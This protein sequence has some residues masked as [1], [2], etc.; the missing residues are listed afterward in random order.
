MNTKIKV[1]LWMLSLVSAFAVTNIASA[2]FS[3]KSAPV[4]ATQTS[5]WVNLTW[6]KVDWATWYLVMY[7]T[8]TGSGWSYESELQDL[9]EWTWAFV[10][11][12]KAWKYFFAVSAF[13][14]EF[15]EVTSPELSADFAWNG[16]SVTTAVTTTS[17][18]TMTN[19]EILA[20]NQVKV[21]FSNDLSTDWAKEFMLTPKDNKNSEVK[22]TE[23]VLEWTKDLVL[24]LETNLDP[25]IEY[26]LV[27]ISA[28]DKDGNTI[29]SG[30]DWM[31][32][33]STPAEFPGAENVELN[34]AWPWDLAVPANGTWV[35]WSWE[36]DGL[37]A[38]AAAES[39][40]ALPTTWPKEMFILILALILG[41]AVAYARRKKLI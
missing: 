25:S 21:S 24:T 17:K 10:W 32:A 38:A 40:E 8:K 23:A 11:G 39:A 13:D 35:T 30:V 9:T 14:S 3:F 34:S 28:T 1:L 22:V 16:A 6:E 27:A 19:V 12:L 26:E 7:G 18:F 2:A 15:N 20:A 4:M 31:V 37:N 36:A 33:F 41:W 5:S 29:E